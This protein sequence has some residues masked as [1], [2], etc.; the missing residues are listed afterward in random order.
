MVL[1]IR[2]PQISPQ[3]RLLLTSMLLLLVMV[4]HLCL[5]L[6][7]VLLLLLLLLLLARKARCSCCQSGA[8]G[9]TI[10]F[11]NARAVRG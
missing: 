6:V 4:L 3:S 7:M 9:K 1:E 2:R 5:L 11:A 8:L 10:F